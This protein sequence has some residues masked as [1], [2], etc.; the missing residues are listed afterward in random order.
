MTR[1]DRDQPAGVPDPQPVGVWTPQRRRLAVQA[2]LAA[3]VLLGPVLF[4]VQYL[5]ASVAN[6]KWI[7]QNEAATQATLRNLWT[8]QE[9]FRGGVYAD[10]DAD[11]VGEYGTF[12][13]LSSGVDV[14]Q[15]ADGANSGNVLK[16]RLLSRAFQGVDEASRI[17][18]SGY[19]LRIYL[20][21]ADGRAVR[22]EPVFDDRTLRGAI[23][24]DAAETD[25]C[26]YAW[27]RVRNEASRRTFF[28]SAGG[29]VLAVEDRRY[30]GDA[31]PAPGAA[32]TSGGLDSLGGAP[33][34]GAVG[35]DEN[36]WEQVK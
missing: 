21:G 10:T 16:A 25:W 9:C 12:R 20:P 5:V 30:E 26:C 4:G 24:P 14:R 8:Q 19:Y 28:I 15:S 22:E 34:V 3:L 6:T 17:S 35:Q 33:A 23:D 11:D 1:V 13:E 27:P 31:G 2:V 7:A 18:R 32:F 36:R 29:V